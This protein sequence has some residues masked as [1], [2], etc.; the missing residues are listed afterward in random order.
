[1]PVAERFDF[2]RF[3]GLLNDQ[4]IVL[5]PGAVTRE[6]SFRIGCIGRIDDRD[7][8]RTIAAID[9]ALKDMGVSGAALKPA[10]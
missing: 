4:G 7:M 1:M 5:Y 3:Y 2:Q 9:G 8:H 6:K 10:A